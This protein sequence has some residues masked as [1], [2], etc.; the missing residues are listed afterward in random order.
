MRNR[1]VVVSSA[2]ALFILMILSWTSGWIKTELDLN[3]D[4][5]TITA[6]VQFVGGAS[7]TD[8]SL[9]IL[10][11]E[12]SLRQADDAAGKGNIVNYVT[13]INSAT[14]NNER[15]TGAQYAT[16]GLEMISPEQ[17]DITVEEFAT[18][19]LAKVEVSP[20]LD[21]ISI[22]KKQ[23]YWSDF[24]ILLK[25]ADTKVLKQ[26]GDE[27]LQELATL[28]GV[29]NIHDN[30]PYGKEQW[31]FSLT[32][33]GRALGLSTADLGRQLRAAYD[34]QRIQIFQEGESEVEVR[35]ML[36]ENE[37]TNLLSIGQ[38]PIKTAAGEMLPLNTLATIQGKRGIDV[39]RHHNTQKT[40]KISGDVDKSVISG[41]E[42]VAYFNENIKDRITEKYHLTTGLDGKSLAGKETESD[43]GLQFLVALALIYIVLAWIFS[44]YT[45]PLAVMAA[46]PM[47]LTGALMGHL[48]LGLYIGPMSILG[49]FTLT[50]IIVNDSIILVSTYKNKV[51]DGIPH[52]QAIEDAVCARLRA[53]ILTSLT[54]VA[55]LF[56]LMLEQAPIAAMFTPLAAAICFGMLYGTVLVLIVIPALLS[57][58]VTLSEK[59]RVKTSSLSPIAPAV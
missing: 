53:V 27:V 44:S 51:A 37:R 59:R 11:L 32:T 58:F 35:L 6:D 47:G 18:L 23:S 17:R 42:V 54:T 2:F 43:F 7:E 48:L 57:I 39:I 52:Q 12:E 3:V 10:H 26:A 22:K 55:G 36:P 8:K 16:I 4:F 38:F 46:I 20:V 50:G 1:R 56:P 25:G 34:G 31:I 41:R 49:L 13:T 21:F 19:W 9:F 40:I 24:S 28:N 5:D 14:I 45:W 15:K 29:K 30:L 33:E